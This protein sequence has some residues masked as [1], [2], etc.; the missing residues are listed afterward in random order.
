MVQTPDVV[1]RDYVTD[2]VPA[3]GTWDPRKADIRALLNFLYNGVQGASAGGLIYDSKAD[4]DADLDHAA[5]SMAWVIGDSTAANNG[6]Y[7]KSG[8]SGSGSWTRIADL[9]H[10]FIKA[11]NIGA[12]TADAIQATTSIPIPT[13]DGA[14]LIAL[15]IVADNTA[16]PVTVSFNGGPALT[17]K[18]IAGN[19]V[20]A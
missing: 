16:S 9:P 5:N 15:P 7:Q 12:G 14:A 13:S 10:G 20:P 17:I 1:F 18:T 6:I 2:G 11:T 4:L 3:S 19:D 8:A